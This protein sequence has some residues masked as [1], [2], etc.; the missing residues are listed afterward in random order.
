MSTMSAMPALRSVAAVRLAP[1]LAIAV[2]AALA[3]APAGSAQAYPSPS[4]DLVRWD[5]VDFPAAFPV[6]R[7]ADRFFGPFPSAADYF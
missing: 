1:V 4:F 2:P 6:S 7:M 3:R 5:D